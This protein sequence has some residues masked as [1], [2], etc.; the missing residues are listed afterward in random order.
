MAAAIL[1]VIATAIYAS[2]VQFWPYNLSLTLDHYAFK[3]LAGG[4]WDAW[5]N[6]L[7]LAFWVT[8]IGTLVIFFNAWLTEKSQG[9]RPLRQGLHFMAMMPMAVPGMV[10]GLSYIFYFNKA[11]NP[12]NWIYG[13][14]AILVLTPWCISIPSAT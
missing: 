9:Y 6:S 4:G 14:F 2:L 11:D 3:A 10:L 8:L 1:A 12:L 7:T 13:T 5:L